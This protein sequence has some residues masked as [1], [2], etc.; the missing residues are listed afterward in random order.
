MK[1]FLKSL[2]VA[3]GVSLAGAAAA[4]AGSVSLTVNNVSANTITLTALQCT[5]CTVVPGSWVDPGNSVTSVATSKDDV[6]VFTYLIQYRAT[7]NAREKGCRA[8]I[9]VEVANGVITNVISSSWL[10]YIGNPTCTTTSAPVISGGNITWG[11]RYN[12]I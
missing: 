10:A 4:Q 2:F 9:T 11:V 12:A 3:A 7:F 8:S 5:G 1:K 6:I